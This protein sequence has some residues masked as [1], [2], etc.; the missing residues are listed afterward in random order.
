MP[1]GSYH[2]TY[3]IHVQRDVFSFQSVLPHRQSSM[4]FYIWCR[5][6]TTCACMSDGDFRWTSDFSFCFCYCIHVHQL[7]LRTKGRHFSRSAVQLTLRIAYRPS[8]Y[9]VGTLGR[10]S[11]SSPLT[12]Q[13]QSGEWCRQD[14]VRGAQN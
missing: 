10:C 7:W 11:F 13:G 9:K 14:L 12:A 4:T 3:G 6:V 2:S 5:N 1:L 8:S